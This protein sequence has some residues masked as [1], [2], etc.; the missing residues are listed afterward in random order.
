[1]YGARAG[2]VCPFLYTVFTFKPYYQHAWING[3]TPLDLIP[4]QLT[5][6]Q[7]V[8]NGAFV[9]TQYRCDLLRREESLAFKQLFKYAH[10]G[11]GI[12]AEVIVL[13]ICRDRYDMLSRRLHAALR[14][15]PNA[16]DY[17]GRVVVWHDPSDPSSLIKRQKEW[18]VFRI[19]EQDCF[20]L[21][22]KIVMRKATPDFVCDRADSRSL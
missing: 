20:R 12:S 8:P 9:L 6:V 4:W 22:V 17:A 16:L 15:N 19:P 13:F 5:R 10:K 1:M 3:P 11:I 14:D 21:I 2:A 7:P 18:S